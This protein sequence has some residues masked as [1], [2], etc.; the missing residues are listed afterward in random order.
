MYQ[1]RISYQTGDSF[2]T[3]DTETILDYDWGDVNVVTQNLKRIREHYEMYQEMADRYHASFKE[4]K[5]EYGKKDWFVVDGEAIDL[6]GTAAR[7]LY[8]Y[9]DDG[10]KFQYSCPWCG[11]FETLYGG[12]VIGP[13]FSL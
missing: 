4:M 2:H 13:Q 9:L 10:T 6:A 8:L 7:C 11:Y 3:E 5:G 1:I 12:E